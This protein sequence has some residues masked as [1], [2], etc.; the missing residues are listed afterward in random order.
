MPALLRVLV[1]GIDLKKDAWELEHLYAAAEPFAQHALVRM[2]DHLG[3]TFDLDGF[4]IVDLSSCM[5]FPAD[6]SLVVAAL[7][8]LSHLSFWSPTWSLWL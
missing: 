3:A 1:V 7:W 5:N 6:T 4:E 2:N 8:Q